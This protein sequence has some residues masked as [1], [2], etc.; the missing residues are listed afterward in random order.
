MGGLHVKPSLLHGDLW[1]GNYLISQEAI[2]YFIDPAVYYGH[3]EVD[4]AMTLLFG[5]FGNDFYSA[6]FKLIPKQAGFEKRIHLYQLYYLLVHLNIFGVS[7]YL[8][9]KEKLRLVQ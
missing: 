1:N 9:V 7:Y 4:I 2:P 8:S 6:Y 3:N 5:G